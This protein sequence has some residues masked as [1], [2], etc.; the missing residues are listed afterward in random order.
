MASSTARK[1][2]CVD[3]LTLFAVPAVAYL[4]IVVLVAIDSVVP[5][6]PS[7]VFVVAAGTLA[8]AGDLDL[9]PAVAAA[10]LGAFVGDQVVYGIGRHKLHGILGRSRFGRRVLISVERTYTKF[11]TASGAAIIAARFMPLGRTAGAGAAGLAGISRGKFSSYSA[12]GVTLWAAWLTGLGYV[13]GANTEGPVWLSVVLGLAVA[14][15][16]GVWLAAI[17]AIVR[18]RRR[19]RPQGGTAGAPTPQRANAGLGVSTQPA[20]STSRESRWIATKPNGRSIVTA[21]PVALYT[22]S[23][24]ARMPIVVTAAASNPKA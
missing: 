12:V 1:L 24:T 2:M 19:M 21:R 20:N 14:L 7:E 22:G 9:A 15:V 5:V 8:A 11:E 17:R 4:V 6:V 23:E 10:A 13:T 16:V 18:T 3:V